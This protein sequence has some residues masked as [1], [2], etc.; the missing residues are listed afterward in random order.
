MKKIKQ[1]ATNLLNTAIALLLISTISSCSKTGNTPQP[2]VAF[3]SVVQA[4]PDAPATNLFLN[5]VR[6]NNQSINYNDELDYFKIYAGKQKPILAST[7]DTSKKVSGT[8]TFVKDKAYSLF[9]A[10]QWA[11]A[12][13]VFVED[14][15]SSPAANMVNGAAFSCTFINAFGFSITGRVFTDNGVGSGMPNDGV[16]NGSEAGM[17]GVIV[18]LTR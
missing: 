3:L 9:L 4:S 5:G 14:N 6:I 15:Y 18:R 12:S 2:D 8:F 11:T 1:S 16:M 13:F 17:A 10:G 7:T